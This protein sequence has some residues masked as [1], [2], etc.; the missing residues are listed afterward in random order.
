VK[1]VCDT[2]PLLSAVNQR[3]QAHR[4]AVSLIA[5]LRRDLLVPDPVIVE[6]DHL[7]RARIGPHAA[8]AFLHDLADGAHTVAYL[9]PGLLRQA[10]DLD[11]RYA[12][13][14]LGVVDA[15]VMAIAERWSL[16]ILTFDFPHFRPTRPP[17][18][19]WRLLINESDY[20]RATGA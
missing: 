6:V 10:V 11:Q 5:T 14:D 4:L 19:H 2:G 9:T 12:D 18:G 1:V 8:R 17:R 20:H 3:D 7:L 16:P 13:L 15:S